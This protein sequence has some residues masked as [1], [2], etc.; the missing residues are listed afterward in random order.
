MIDPGREVTLQAGENTFVL[1]AGNRALRLIERESGKPLPDLLEYME[2]GS[3]GAMTTVLWAMLQHHHPDMTVDNVDDLI[4]AA[5]YEA[6]GVAVG[7]AAN[8]AFGVSQDDGA[9]DLGKAA[10]LNGA[11]PGIGPPSSP[12]RSRPG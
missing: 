8:R 1:Y 2:R 3:V 4:D 6:S 11:T 5:G 12:A 9:T 7:E 10:A